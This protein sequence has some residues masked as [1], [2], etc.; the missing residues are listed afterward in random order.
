M[1]QQGVS[2]NA[3]ILVILVIF[4]LAYFPSFLQDSGR[5]SDDSSKRND[6]DSHLVTYLV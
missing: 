3:G 1:R 2:Q 5:L 6:S 4:N